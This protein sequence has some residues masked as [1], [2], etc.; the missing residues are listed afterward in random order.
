M[1][2]RK[3]KTKISKNSVFPCIFNEFS[4]FG[5]R[6]FTFLKKSAV[7]ITGESPCNGEC[8]SVLGMARPHGLLNFQSVAFCEKCSRASLASIWAHI[9]PSIVSSFFRSLAKISIS[10]K[11]NKGFITLHSSLFVV[12]VH[13]FHQAHQDS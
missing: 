12:E 9:W 1:K 8:K 13:Y 11:E 3:S 7:A 10:L 6:R 4:L 5:F 2:T